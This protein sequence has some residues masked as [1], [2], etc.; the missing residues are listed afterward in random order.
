MAENLVE[1]SFARTWAKLLTQNHVGFLYGHTRSFSQINYITDKSGN[2]KRYGTAYEIFED[3]LI[4]IGLFIDEVKKLG[5]QKIVLLGHSLG[6]NKVIYYMSEQKD[7]VIK[8]VILASPPDLVGLEDMPE[9]EK[10]RKELIAEAKHNIET[11]DPRKILRSEIWGEYELSSQTYL[12]LYSSGG[13]SDNLPVLRNPE[14]WSQL[15]SLTAPAV[16]FMGE[17]DDIRIRDIKKDLA[18]IKSKATNCPNFATAIIAEANHYYH[19]Q[20]K[21]TA[22]L[23]LDWLKATL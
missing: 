11:G 14:H 23:I 17:N 6:C 19:G 21:E 1:D 12:S 4:D 16:A 8:G 7:D 3:C 13:K 2:R 5:Y 9:Y 18:L 20:E 10:N 22:K 15:E